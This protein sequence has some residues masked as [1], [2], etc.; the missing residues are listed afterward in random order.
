MK[1]LNIQSNTIFHSLHY[2]KEESDDNL[3][4]ISIFVLVFKLELRS[5]FLTGEKQ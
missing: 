3:A 4:A 1:K 5:S 2:N